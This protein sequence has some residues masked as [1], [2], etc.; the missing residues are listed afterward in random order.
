[1]NDPT[2]SR[3]AY[4]DPSADRLVAPSASRNAKPIAEALAEL[5][6]GG[7]GEA[8]EIGS[9]TGQHAVACARALPHLTWRPTDPDE[10]HLASIVAWRAKAALRNLV[11]PERL[12]ASADWGAAARPLRAV[13]SANVIHIAPWTL[14]EG[15]FRG[16]GKALAPG[17][18]LLLYGPF[19]EHGEASEGNRAFDVSLRERDPE[20]G[21]RDVADLAGLAAANGLGAP[22]RT[23]MP[24][25][26]LILSFARLGAAT[27][28][29]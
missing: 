10:R 9:G 25:N 29:D 20:W 4:D 21:V 8:L 13:F 24:A 16:A 11:A 1:M 23:P 18:L 15:I 26:N 17:G 12:D 27:E 19:F 28:R 22:R 3:P 6:V 14:A 5:L 7:D 2:S